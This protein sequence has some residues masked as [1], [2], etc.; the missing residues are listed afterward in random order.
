VSQNLTGKGCWIMNDISD[1]LK[2][3]LAKAV[4]NCQGK[5]IFFLKGKLKQIFSVNF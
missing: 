3:P 5:L 2:A 1:S 4:P